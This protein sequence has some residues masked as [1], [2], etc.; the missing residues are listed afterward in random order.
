MRASIWILGFKIRSI[1]GLRCHHFMGN[2][3]GNNGNIERLYFL[4][5]QNHYRWWLQPWSLRMLALW[6]KSYEK[7]TK[8]IKKQRL[9]W[10]KI[11]LVKAMIFPVVIYE[12]ENWTIKKVECQRI[13]AFELWCWRNSWESLGLQG[14]QTSQSERKSVLNIHWKDWCWSWNSNPLAT[15]CEELT[16]WNRS[17][18]WKRL[19]VGGEGDNSRWDGWMASLTQ[20]TWVWVNSGSWWWQGS[21][22]LQRVGHDWVTKLNWYIHRDRY[23]GICLLKCI[24]KDE[25]RGS[26]DL[27]QEL[28]M[29]EAKL[30]DPIPLHEV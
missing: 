30:N 13:D 2:R 18:C 3:W 21:L 14:D 22:G 9:C 12:F 6:K 16:H 15:W 8:H 23:K 7:P 27:E 4:G 24:Y 29:R 20:W 11:G 19:K 28:E 25:E 1:S 26:M 10:Q 5:L 17:W